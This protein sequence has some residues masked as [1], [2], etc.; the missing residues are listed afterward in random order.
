MDVSDDDDQDDRQSHRH[1][2]SS[3]SSS[4]TTR[5]RMPAVVVDTKNLTVPQAEGTNSSPVNYT[6]SDIILLVT[7]IFLFVIFNHHTSFLNS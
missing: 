2:A 6:D 5:V 4:A 3:S 7:F 1:Q